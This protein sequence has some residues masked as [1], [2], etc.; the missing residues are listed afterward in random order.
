VVATVEE[1]EE[2]V[3]EDTSLATTCTSDDEGRAIVVGHSSALCLIQLGEIG[4]VQRYSARHVS[5]E[6]DMWG[7]A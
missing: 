5:D 7:R 6:M 2:L 3:D 1:V 4:E